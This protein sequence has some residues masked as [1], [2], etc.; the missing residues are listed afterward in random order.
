MVKKSVKKLLFLSIIIFLFLSCKSHQNFVT[1]FATSNG[2]GY[3]IKY[4]GKELIIQE[5]IPAVN[6]KISFKSKKEAKRTGNLVLIKLIK[7]PSA[8][9]DISINELDSLKISY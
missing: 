3:K 4:A 8:F 7:S 9:P 2:W 6:K 5:N 1:T